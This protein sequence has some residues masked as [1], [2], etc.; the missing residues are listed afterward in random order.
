MDNQDAKMMQKAAPK[1][2]PLEVKMFFKRHCFLLDVP[3][4]QREGLTRILCLPLWEDVVKPTDSWLSG[5][6]A[7]S[8][9]LGP[10]LKMPFNPLKR[11]FIR[12]GLK[13]MPFCP[14]ASV[15]CDAHKKLDP[16]VIWNL[17][18]IIERES[19]NKIRVLRNAMGRVEDI[20]EEAED[21]IKRM[22][23]L[24]GLWSTPEDFR[25][26]YAF[27]FADCLE[28]N[29]MHLSALSDLTQKNPCDACNLAALG[30]RE[31]C[32]IDLR[33]GLLARQQPNRR[34]N[35][36]I[37][38]VDSWISWGRSEEEQRKV[39]SKSRL[40]AKV[41]QQATEM[42]DKWCEKHPNVGDLRYFDTIPDWPHRHNKQEPGKPHAEDE[43]DRGSGYY[44]EV[45][46][47]L[48]E[49][50]RITRQWLAEDM[51]EEEREIAMEAFDSTFTAPSAVPPRLNTMGEAK[52]Q[53]RLSRGD[54]VDPAYPAGSDSPLSPH[55]LD[56]AHDDSGT[57]VSES[58]YTAH[59]LSTAGP[60][61]PNGYGGLPTPAHVPPSES[62]TINKT[63]LDY[64]DL[65][66][67]PQ[68][69]PPIV[70]ASAKPKMGYGGL[71]HPQTY[72]PDATAPADDINIGS[73]G[74]RYPDGVPHPMP[75]P[76]AGTGFDIRRLD[77]DRAR[78]FPPP[79][80][81]SFY[82]Q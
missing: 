7:A 31:R 80:A 45:D 60:A 32:L 17:T 61:R 49:Q 22:S 53:P 4:E 47:D 25:H 38:I 81:S 55:S 57:W 73:D 74:L 3:P 43:Q 52:D 24:G 29:E 62:T 18:A 14:D 10:S 72:R 56:S 79:P 30:G 41:I 12:G 78:R 39:F 20:S 19:L 65:P 34:C 33:A 28:L 37:R 59:P 69:L 70:V 6:A 68:P 9:E 11:A 58:V 5:Q 36:L 50:A 66:S 51:A 48:R 71:P 76:A 77:A 35:P 46:A 26:L 40:L 8:K 75:T 15:L 82:S 54:D 27:E 64:G 67:A 44:G 13:K 21:W 23:L 1:Q 2:I 42:I 16:R 63:E